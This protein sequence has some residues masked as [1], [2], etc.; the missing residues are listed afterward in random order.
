[1]PQC[2]WSLF[3]PMPVYGDSIS[4]DWHRV[5]PTSCPNMVG[6][7]GAAWGYSSLTPALGTRKRLRFLKFAGYLLDIRNL[8]QFDM[9]RTFLGRDL[10]L[11]TDICWTAALNDICLTIVLTSPERPWDA[12]IWHQWLMSTAHPSDVRN[13]NQVMIYTRP[14]FWRPQNTLG[15]SRSN[16]SGGRPRTFPNVR[17][18]CRSMT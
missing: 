9:F 14:L 4:T 12:S 8:P 18:W 10:I 5:N 13:W 2:G 7:L 3:I 17:L 16:A 15:I 1:M 6:S 11:M